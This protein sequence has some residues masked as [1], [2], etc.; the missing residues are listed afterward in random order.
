MTTALSKMK[1]LRLDRADGPGGLSLA[2]VD[3][4]TPARGEVRVALKAA[5]INHR[6]LWITRGQYPGM[7]LPC[8]LGC[9]GAGVIEAVGEGVDASRV[10]SA[11]MLYPGLNWGPD[12]R[13]P[14]A[15]FGLLGMPGPGTLAQFVCVADANALDK[16]DYLSFEEAAA[17]PLAALTAWRGLVTKAGLTSSENL[18]ITGAG[19]GVATFALQ[20]AVA[21]GAAVFVTS[22]HAETLEHAI[23]LGV[24]EGF[25]YRDEGWP[26]ALRKAAGGVDVAFDG[27]PAAAF[28]GYS[29]A[30][31]RGARVVIYGST[32]GLQFPCS[33]ADLFLK[34][35][36]IMG[37]NVGT[38]QELQLLLAFLQQHQ[39][40]PQIERTFTLTDA[41]RAL[42]HLEGA[43][44]FGKVVV[45]I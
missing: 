11:V 13:F 33:A 25:N 34:N 16:P 43:H 28:A 22:S 10:G 42:A 21:L 7:Q 17:V 9:D 5:S 30:L 1:A 41:T 31:N 26:K 6:E 29:R 27:A 2:D 18:L 23:K 19:G 14:A 37:T 36:N 12:L 24:R 15:D 40:R 44:G 35:L 45:K 38:R 3:I 4:P 32:A 39:I 20:I 8:T